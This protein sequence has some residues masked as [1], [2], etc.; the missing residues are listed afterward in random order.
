[1]PISSGI[2]VKDE[3]I[4]TFRD[5]IN[6]VGP[7]RNVKKMKWMILKVTDDLKEIEIES[8]HDPAKDD[9]DKSIYEDFRT[10]LSEKPGPKADTI[11]PRYG[12]YKVDYEIPGDIVRKT[13]KIVGFS[14]V[15]ASTQRELKVVYSTSYE[16]L[17]SALGNVQ[18]S[19]QADEPSEVEFKYVLKE[20]DRT[21][22][23][24]F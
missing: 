1:M 6:S 18:V 15:P 11:L 22:V 8:V 21:A 17:K 23:N 2:T 4:T 14:W 7:S 20:C 3:C 13:D 10:R 19:I 24:G 12:I 5:K 9:S 16:A